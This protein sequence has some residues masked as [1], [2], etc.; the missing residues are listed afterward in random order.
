MTQGDWRV[1]V[2]EGKSARSTI[3]INNRCSAPHLF[4]IKSN[5]KFLQFEQPTDSVLIEAGSSKQ[6]GVRLSAI[7]LKSKQY[8]GKVVVE[9]ID[10]K[11]EHGCN[12]ALEELSV[13]M[14]VKPYQIAIPPARDSLKGRVVN[15]QNNPVAGAKV[16]VPGRAVVL[17]DSK[18]EFTIRG[19]PSSE[20]LAVSFSAPGFMDTTRI[21]KVGR[22]S[23]VTSVVVIW[24]RATP[25]SMD[26]ERGGKLTFPGGTINFPPR[27]LVNDAGRPL[28]GRVKVS[29]SSLDVSDR[30]QVRAAPG[31]FTARMRN[32]R[33]RQLETFG[34]FEVF[35]EDSEGRRANLA[36]GRQVAIE[37]SIPRA[38]R[39]KAL[40]RVGLYDFDRSGGLWIEQ[41][42]LELS[43]VRPFYT[44]LINNLITS[45]NADMTLYT[46]CI[47]LKILNEDGS[48]APDWTRVEAEGVSYAGT[49]PIGYTTQ[50]EVCLSVKSCNETVRVV[51]YHPN[52]SAI[53]SCP[54]RIKTPCHIASAADCGNPTDCPLQPQEII[55]PGTTIGTFYHDLNA[56]DPGNWQKAHNWTNYT[57]SSN[58]YDVWWYNTHVVFNNDGIMRLRLD[59]TPPPAASPTPVPVTY[60][61]G[62]YR[63]INTYG[64]GTY[65]VCLK[66]ASGDGLMT[67]FFTYTGPPPGTAPHHE[68]DIEFRGKNT[69]EVW[70]NFFYDNTDHGQ[71]HGLVFDAAEDFH[72][73][74][75]VWT[76]SEIKWYVDGVEIHTEY[77]ANYPQWPT[78]PGQIMVNLW[79]GNSNSNSWLGQFTYL[80][81]INAE[82]DW[83]RYTPP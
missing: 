73:Y 57:A 51:A 61:S 80:G 2:E 31:D 8:R 55:L 26:A 40:R 22:A 38:L 53:N 19:L 18:G 54:V 17:T 3:T 67:S 28:Q 60:S 14:V 5:D 43:A 58:F 7:G 59:D 23:I 64:Y 41:G 9:C 72:R 75:F 78:I 30:R 6:L 48:P 39:R 34:V 69:G 11:K 50:G 1:E 81:P 36:K 71:S 46:T 33:I 45:W 83:I 27:A 35:V 10:C 37:L 52:N 25:A 47:K 16:S 63:T 70:T 56:D 82:Y 32:N 79:C 74:K 68:I 62:E 76:S 20:R 13:E 4:R 29:F 42:T 44:G 12:Q 65:E 66:A 21:Y 15:P 24:P 49:S 77:A